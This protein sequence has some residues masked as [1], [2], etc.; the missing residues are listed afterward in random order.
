MGDVKKHGCLTENAEWAVFANADAEFEP[1]E[2]GEAEK[3][4]TEFQRIISERWRVFTHVQ[5][6]LPGVTRPGQ[7]HVAVSVQAAHKGEDN[8]A[9]SAADPEDISS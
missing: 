5:P 7:E 9:G 8:Q 4:D 3:K 6:L 2:K 1:A